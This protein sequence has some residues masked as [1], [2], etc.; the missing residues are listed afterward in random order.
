M[1][2]AK[3]KEKTLGFEDAMKELEVL[4]DSMENDSLT[5]EESLAMFEKGVKLTRLCQ[6]ALSKVEQDIKILTAEGETDF[7][8]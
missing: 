8:D 3:K 5:L 1:D 7:N 4:V 2:V 6:Q